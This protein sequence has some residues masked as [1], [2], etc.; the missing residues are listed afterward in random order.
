MCSTCGCGQ[1]DD[2]VKI[3]LIGENK[4]FTAV[5]GN[6]NMLLQHD[7]PHAHDHH[8]HD[9]SPGHHH[10]NVNRILQLNG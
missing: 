5:E 6:H 7:H 3:T 9:H 8:A 4:I 10:E 1:P 2:D